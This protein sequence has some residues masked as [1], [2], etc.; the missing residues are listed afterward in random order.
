MFLK[1]IKFIFRD[2]KTGGSEYVLYLTK[3][4]ANVLR[5]E[6]GVDISLD[7]I[8]PAVCLH[9]RLDSACWVRGTDVLV[10]QSEMPLGGVEANW[11]G[12]A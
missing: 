4:L 2:G 6:I 10:A 12:C 1:G 9:V 3:L 11:Y 8:E 7:T 5:C